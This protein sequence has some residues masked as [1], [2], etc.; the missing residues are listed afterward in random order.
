MDCAPNG[1]WKTRYDFG[2]LGQLGVQLDWHWMAVGIV[3]GQQEIIFSDKINW[4]ATLHNNSPAL[5]WGDEYMCNAT[6]ST[7]LPRVA[8]LA[9]ND[10]GA[11][12]W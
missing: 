11:S 5:P 6:L 9:R 2:S 10:K 8:T 12:S 3:L 1:T 7:G 4:I